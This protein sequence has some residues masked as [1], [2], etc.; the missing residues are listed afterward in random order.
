[1]VETIQKGATRFFIP[2]CGGNP[3]AKPEYF[4]HNKGQF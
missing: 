3:A 2:L 4:R 1:M